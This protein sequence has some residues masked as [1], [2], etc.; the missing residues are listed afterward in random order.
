MTPSYKEACEALRVLLDD[1][2]RARRER[3]SARDS[4]RVFQQQADEFLAMWRNMKRE[5]DEAIAAKN[6]AER[7][8]AN[9]LAFACTG[10]TCADIESRLAR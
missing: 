7:R 5:R 6:E 8:A 4:L 9:A 3:D 2:E 10:S 1:V